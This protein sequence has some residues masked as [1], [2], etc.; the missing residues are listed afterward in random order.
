[1]WVF[2]GQTSSGFVADVWHSP[3][4]VNWTSATGN[5]PWIARRAFAAAAFSGKLWV[6]GGESVSDGR[7]N[8]VWWSD[9]GVLWQEATA[10]APWTPRNNLNCVV[11]DGKLWVMGGFDGTHRND[12]WWS[13]DGASWTRAMSEHE[14]SPRYGHASAVLNSRI[15]VLGGIDSEDTR[16]NDVWAS[17]GMVSGRKGY[18]YTYDTVSR[19][20]AVTPNNGVH[21][22][23]AYD[24][25]GN[26]L[27]KRVYSDV[28]VSEG[29]ANPPRAGWRTTP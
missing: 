26:R 17:V 9:D 20:T 6:L 10:C 8:D 21:I 16:L 19:L 14:W 15:W 27:Q 7:K 2:G 1:M 22:T 13:A 4:G 18:E 25:A 23:Y 12:V 11:F 28:A 29:P 24:A 5:A 3:D